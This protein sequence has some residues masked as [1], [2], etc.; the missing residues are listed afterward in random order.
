MNSWPYRIIEVDE[1]GPKNLANMCKH[2]WSD[3]AYGMAVAITNGK[4]APTSTTNYI[5]SKFY[6]E[7]A[8]SNL[9]IIVSCVNYVDGCRGACSLVV[10]SMHDCKIYLE[11]KNRAEMILFRKVLTTIPISEPDWK[12]QA[13]HFLQLWVTF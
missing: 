5:R 13:V 10:D 1:F 9:F 7:V 8:R 11:E 3:P 4:V 2:K 12:E 6:H